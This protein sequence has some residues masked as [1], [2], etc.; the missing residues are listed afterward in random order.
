MLQI[1]SVAITSCLFF[2]NLQQIFLTSRFMTRWSTCAT[3]LMIIGHRSLA[4]K[5]HGI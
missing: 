5:I 2:R 4:A 3:V 1:L